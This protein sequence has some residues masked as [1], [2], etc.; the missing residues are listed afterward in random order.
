LKRRNRKFHKEHPEEAKPLQE[1]LSATVTGSAAGTPGSIYIELR[2]GFKA[3]QPMVIAVEIEVD[4]ETGVVTPIKLVT[5]MF[6]GRMIN[7]GIV[8]GQAIGAAVQTL[9][10][11]LW[12]EM[13]YDEEASIYLSKDFTDYK[14]PRAL[15]VPEIETV[16]LEEV[17]EAI[18]PYEELPY[19]G[20]GIG[21]MGAWGGPVAMA[22]ALYSAIGV[23][24]KKTP[25]TAEAVLE[26][27]GKE[28]RK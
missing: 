16:L 5:G 15:D 20:R 11:A 28:A 9:G 8:R 2:P 1:L 13:K 10:M 4:I 19:G 7:Q 25:M 3:Q 26:A 22:S 12:E 14:I 23:R 27:L 17:D 18:P 6:P 21:E 24:I